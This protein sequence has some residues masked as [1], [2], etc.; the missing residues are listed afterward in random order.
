MTRRD[1]WLSNQILFVS[2]QWA[3]ARDKM[4]KAAD[5]ISLDGQIKKTIWGQFWSAHQVC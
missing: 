5:M 3:D 2:L 1:Y 4:E